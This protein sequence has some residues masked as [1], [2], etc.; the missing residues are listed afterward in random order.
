[1]AEVASTVTTES[2]HTD[3]EHSEEVTREHSNSEESMNDDNDEPE[4]EN[5]NEPSSDESSDDETTVMK[6]VSKT[7]KST[8]TVRLEPHQP[9][10]VEIPDN[11]QWWAVPKLSKQLVQ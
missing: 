9:K 4:P 3:S 6:A 2:T 7:S 1:M 11:T 10:I 5:D 8:I